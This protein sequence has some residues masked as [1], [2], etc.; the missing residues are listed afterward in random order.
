MMK[1]IL[2]KNLLFAI[3]IIGCS[4]CSTYKLFDSYESAGI[5]RDVLGNSSNKLYMR[6]DL[7]DVSL[8]PNVLTTS[9]RQQLAHILVK[10]LPAEYPY[11]QLDL[12]QA[13]YVSLYFDPKDYSVMEV[14]F[15]DL[16]DPSKS[17]FSRKAL[18]SMERTI[19][20]NLRAVPNRRFIDRHLDKVRLA[21]STFVPHT[22]GFSI[23]QL[24]ALK[25]GEITEENLL[26][27]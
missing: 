7:N 17:L 22:V 11:Q 14:Y 23:K 12:R 1:N 4:S 13:I 5:K 16:S 3:L 8:D 15:S 20:K 27:F 9:Y 2:F 6:D 26:T 21:N 18:R 25:N 19:K 10:Q 24:F